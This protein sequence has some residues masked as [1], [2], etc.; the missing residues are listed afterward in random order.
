MS[1]AVQQLMKDVIF[2]VVGGV[3]AAVMVAPLLESG[4]EIAML[5]VIVPFGWRWC[6]NIITAVGPI[7][8]V[9]KLVLS[10]FVGFFACPILLVK[11]IV[12]IVRTAS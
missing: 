1:R 9:I 6:S 3:I 10:V 7:G 2:A 11:D 4:T 5:G 12:D 8:I